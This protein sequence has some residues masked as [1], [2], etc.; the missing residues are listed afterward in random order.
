MEKWKTRSI[1]NNYK[2]LAHWNLPIESYEKWLL[3]LFYLG[4]IV[5]SLYVLMLPIRTY[6]Q[7]P[8]PPSI[9]SRFW[10]PCSTSQQSKQIF[11]IPC[12]RCFTLSRE[13]VSVLQISHFTMSYLP[14]SGSKLLLVE[15]F[16]PILSDVSYLMY[17]ILMYPAKLF[18][19]PS[20]L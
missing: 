4:W 5:T 8:H 6:L 2:K 11:I 18:N 7:H 1:T 19:S 3:R 15:Y 16:Q 10:F 9:W 17:L 12:F 20:E 13:F 14:R